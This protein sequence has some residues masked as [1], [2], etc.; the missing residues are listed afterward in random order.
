MAIKQPDHSSFT[1]ALIPLC[2]A[3]LLVACGGGGG[4][5]GGSDSS[6]AVTPGPVSPDS[7]TIAWTAPVARADQSPLSLSE[8]G[9]Y[10]VYY[11]TTEG[12]YPNRVDVSDSSAVE[13]TLDNLPLGSYYFVVTTYDG[14]GRESSFSPVVVKTI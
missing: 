8:I 3:A 14:T 11:G 7:V 6:S 13:V 2:M 4:G 10:R 9:G 1:K 12:E 5:G